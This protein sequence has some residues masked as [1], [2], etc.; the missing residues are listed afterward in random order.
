MTP[1][2]TPIAATEANAT[3]GARFK[4]GRIGGVHGSVERILTIRTDLKG[5]SVIDLACGDGRTTH[6]LR[7]LGA[8]VKPYDL[9]PELCLLDDRPESL[10]L[11]RKTAIPDEAADMVVLQEVIEHLPNQLFALQEIFRILKPGGEA[12]ITTPSRSSLVSKFSYLC[13]ESETLK[14]PPCGPLESVWMQDRNSDKQYYG[15]LWLVGIQQLRTLAMLA[16]FKSLRI[17]R[18]NVSRSSMLLMIVFYPIVVLISLRALLRGYRSATTAIRRDRLEQFK[19][20][21]NPIMLTNKFL[22]AVLRK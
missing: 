6:L 16:G 22:I 9:F 4:Y 21:V 15:H 20:N 7:S 12:L 13:F 14:V 19:L 17:K 5:M 18:S 8:I 11:Q 3:E 2:A 10:D 1:S